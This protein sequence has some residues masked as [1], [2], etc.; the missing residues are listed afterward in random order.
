MVMIIDSRMRRNK[1]RSMTSREI[2]R[3]IKVN[4]EEEIRHFHHE[5][6]KEIGSSPHN[7]EKKAKKYSVPLYERLIMSRVLHFENTNRV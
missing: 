1:K 3:N 6:R 7:D 4:T 5:E 2:E